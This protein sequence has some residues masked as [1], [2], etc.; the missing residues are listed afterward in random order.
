ML[1][2]QT[3]DKLYAMKLIGMARALKN[4]LKQLP[5]GISPSRNTLEYWSI[6]SGPG[7]RINVS[8][9]SS[10]RPNSN[11]RPPWRTSTTELHGA[12]KNLS[13]S[14]SPPVSGSGPTRTFSS[15]VLQAWAKHFWL[16][17]LPK[18][19][20]GKDCRPSTFALPSS[21]TRSL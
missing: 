1:N 18:R 11:F 3:F 13:F 7:K 14:A 6:T 2:E 12:S 16:V 4:S 10:K 19:L 17:P 5:S 9:I 21:S 8:N 15:R 20:V